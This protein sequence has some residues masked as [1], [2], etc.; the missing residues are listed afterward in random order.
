[1]PNSKTRIGVISDPPPTPVC[2]TSRPTT[3][4]DREYS[5]LIE[6]NKSMDRFNQAR[7]SA[8]C[9][10]QGAPYLVAAPSEMDPSRLD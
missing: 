8:G 10:G 9:E 3:N 6:E 2:P 5:G 7:P 1:M 4:P